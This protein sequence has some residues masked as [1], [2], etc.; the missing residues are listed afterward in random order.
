MVVNSSSASETYGWLG[1][2]PRLREW[3]GDRQVKNLSESSFTIKN[4]SFESTVSVK[5]NDVEDDN[6]GQYTPLFQMLGDDAARHP[7]ELVFP[8]LKNG[9]NGIC[10]D[11][12]Y[13]F[14]TDHP[15]LD[16]NG[17]TISVSNTGG[18]SGN[19]WFMLDTSRP[20]LP[21]IFQKR[22]EYSFTAKDDPKDDNV[23]F[24]DEFVYGTDGRVN[25]GYGLWQLAYGSKQTLDPANFKAAVQS[26]QS[27]KADGGK[28]MN[29]KPTLLVVG[30]SNQAAALELVKAERNAAG[31]TNIW[32]GTVEV[33]V[34]PYLD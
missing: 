4:K 8:L 13:F 23:F 7:D 21:I 34:V 24:K 25:A 19:A 16:E 5:R 27:R 32:Q 17:D 10:Y 1:Q 15:V 11:G 20:I 14:D 6:L 9:F 22:R 3:I 28:P 12:Q 29:L 33:L 18:G 26:L 31:A 30:P 2:T